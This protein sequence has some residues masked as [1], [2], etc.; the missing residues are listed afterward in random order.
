LDRQE[1]IEKLVALMQE[2]RSGREEEAFTYLARTFPEYMEPLNQIHVLVNS[3]APKPE[4]SR[5]RL[6]VKEQ[7]LIAAAVLASQRDWERFKPHV[8][9]CMEHAS[10]EEIAEVL[11]VAAQMSGSPAIRTGVQIM[12]DIEKEQRQKTA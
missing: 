10:M 11:M 4:G 6:T 5:F 8:R 9:R 3:Y 2:Q 7:E 1:K 12:L